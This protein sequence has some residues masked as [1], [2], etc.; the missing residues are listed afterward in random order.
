M[1]DYKRTYYCLKKWV[2]EIQHDIDKSDTMS[3]Q[4]A[5]DWITATCENEIFDGTYLDDNEYNEM[6]LEDAGSYGDRY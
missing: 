4:E 1:E 2:E 5:V 3:Q 6:L